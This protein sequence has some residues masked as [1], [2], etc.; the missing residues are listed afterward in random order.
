MSK[1]YGLIGMSALAAL[2]MHP[3]EG[4]AGSFN[5]DSDSS[6]PQAV[7]QSAAPV[8]PNGMSQWNEPVIKTI[9]IGTAS[10]I[11]SQGRDIEL[12]RATKLIIPSNWTVY[13]DQGVSSDMKV[14]WRDNNKP[15]TDVLGDAIKD[16]HILAVVNWDNHTV[17]FNGI[18]SSPSAVAYPLKNQP[19][20]TPSIPAWVI[21]SNTAMSDTV[22]SWG[23]SAGWEVVWKSTDWIPDAT[24]SVTGDF[25][26]A[27]GELVRAANK[28]HIP[29]TATFYSNNIVVFD[30]SNTS[31]NK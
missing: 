4:I 16:R 8:I 12:I 21:S 27:V 28:Q 19:A 5:M 11:S 30:S 7:I 1:K 14:S 23:K 13:A 20:K 31:L 2:S 26:T 25:K 29:L 9:G 24:S 3:L 22:R 6:A 18:K 15:W 10:L 17:S